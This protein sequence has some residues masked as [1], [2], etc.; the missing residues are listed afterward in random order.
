MEQQFNIM[1]EQAIYEPYQGEMWI[2]TKAD[3]TTAETFKKID[4]DFC[5]LVCSPVPRTMEGVENSWIS[6]HMVQYI[7]AANNDDKV[8]RLGLE[9]MFDMLRGRDEWH[10]KLLGTVIPYGIV[11]LSAYISGEEMES[12]LDDFM[13]EFGI[14]APT[15]ELDAYLKE[16]ADIH[17]SALAIAIAEGIKKG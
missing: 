2:L 9:V 4:E 16:A 12:T 17:V 3:I 10:L 11:Q 15:S 14:A 13:K 8:S 7:T 6:L 1:R 5:D